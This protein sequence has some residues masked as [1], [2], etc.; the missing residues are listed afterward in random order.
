MIKIEGISKKYDSFHL[1]NLNFEIEEG[2]YLVALGPSGAGKTVLLEIIAGLEKAD[3]GFI[4][5]VDLD[6]IGFIY[7]DSALFPH[8]NVYDNIAYGLKMR[9]VDKKIINSKIEEISLKLKINNLL[10]REVT[11]LSGG[12]KQRVAI[13]RALVINPKLFLL[14][15]PTGSLDPNLRKDIQELLKNIHKETKATFIHV[16]HDFEEAVALSDR[17]AVMNEGTIIQIGRS[18]EI[19]RSPKT[20]FVAD[21]VGF[22]NLFSGRIK[23]NFFING[24]FKIYTEAS[25]AESVHAAVK[26]ND[27]ILSKERFESSARNSVCGEVVEI[28]KKINFVEI[29][30]FVGVKL[31]SFITESSLEKMNLKE[32]DKVWATFKSSSVKF[33][34]S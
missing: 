16:T 33:F 27:I 5:G 20:K 28:R 24:D 9:K 11:N 31:K 21:F 34:F 13:A 1:Y 8:L 30:I 22:E 18:E 25:E 10:K 12:E 4:E 14:D 17:I 19:F 32:G 26:A 3:I 2:E 29:S 6:R 23:N 15:E 7:Q